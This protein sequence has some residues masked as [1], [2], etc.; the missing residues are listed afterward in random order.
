MPDVRHLIL[1][2]GDHLDPN[3]PALADADPDRDVVIMAEVE[4]E[5]RR[6]PNHRQR[7]AVFLS[8]M[9][10]LRDHLRAEGFTV[11]YQALGDADALASLPDFLRQEM[12]AHAPARV[13]LTEPG[14]FSLQEALCAAA[15]EAGVPL[16]L[17]EDTHFL[18]SQHE[19]AAWA[20]GRKSLV[21]GHFYRWMRQRY[22]VLLDGGE[23]AGGRWNYDEKN[24]DSFGKDGP[25]D[26]LPTPVGFAPDATTQA[27]LDA[28]A[29]LEDSLYGHAEGFDWP[30]T[31]EDAEAALDDFLAHRLPH[32]GQYQDALW[33]GEP[34]LYHARLSAALNLKL[35]DPRVVLRRAEEAYRSGHA[36]LA[37]VE[38]FIRQVLGW[39]EF[40]RGIY[41]LHMPGYLD[42]NA[43]DAHEALPG[44]YWTGETDMHCLHTVITQLLE[45][46]Y[47]HHIQRLMV[48]GLFALLYGVEPLEVHDWY[49]ALYI[50][51][52]EWVTLPNTTGMAL[53]ADGGIVG[54]KPY[55][56]SG[57]YL[58][59]MSNYCDACRFD[60]SAA[61]GDDAC[62]F[63][64]LYWD[65]LM[66]HE[67]RFA[68]HHRMALQVRNL[69]RKA[70]EARTAIAERAEA[71]RAQ[72]RKGAL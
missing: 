33:T 29:P 12:D 13:I 62:P 42:H 72:V 59:R 46:A 50:D 32:F 25:P 38:G 14:R 10:H 57:K 3:G 26:D 36:P 34:Y 2:L 28:L 5:V 20:D 11:V 44:W 9:R 21:M 27:V 1:L 41:W 61:T 24:R 15:A 23:P 17:R 48:T 37:A 39:R 63:T 69:Q 71:V 54:T 40:I 49:M 8:A 30:V 70:P 4:A 66:R 60:P 52:V 6:Y 16:D 47:A 45:T 58:Q 65:F 67:D 18:C 55:I 35:L 19:F 31:P 53:H 64:T 51:S 56:A 22:E 7:V 68:G 43:L